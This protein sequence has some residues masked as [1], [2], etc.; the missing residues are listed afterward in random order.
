MGRLISKAKV[1]VSLPLQVY[2]P[3]WVESCVQNLEYKL[4]AALVHIRETPKQGHY[5][6]LLVESTGHMWWTDDGHKA[7]RPTPSDAQLIIRNSYILF[8]RPSHAAGAS[9]A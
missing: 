9:R 8:F 4:C 6:A 7:T 1:P 2:L 5:R 3:S